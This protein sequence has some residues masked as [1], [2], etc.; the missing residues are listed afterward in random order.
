MCTMCILHV[1][2]PIRAYL[3][4]SIKAIH[5]SPPWSRLVGFRASVVSLSPLYRWFYGAVITAHLLQSLVGEHQEPVLSSASRI[6]GPG[7]VIQPKMWQ[8]NTQIVYWC[9]LIPE[10]RGCMGT[11]R[12]LTHSHR[13]ANQVRCLLQSR[14]GRTWQPSPPVFARR[15]TQERTLY[16]S[17]SASFS[18]PSW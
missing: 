13:R 10:N 3:S 6:A 12:G 4:E 16:C 5:R 1:C 17:C 8:R 11:L 15:K 18:C 9:S 7:W 2:R 14:P